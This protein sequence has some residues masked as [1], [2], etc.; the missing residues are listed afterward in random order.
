MDCAEQKALTFSINLHCP[1]RITHNKVLFF[2]ILNNRKQGE[3]LKTLQLSA[4][5]VFLCSNMNQLRF[6][7]YLIIASFLWFSCTD[8][9]TTE[10]F[11]AAK[12]ATLD[13]A[14]LQTYFTARNLKDSV[15]KTS[16]GLYYRITKSNPSEPL[17]T[18]GKRVFVRYE[19]RLLTDTIFDSN[20]NS[21]TAFRFVPGSGAVIKAWEEGILYFRKGEE[22]YLYAPSGLGY[23][24]SPTGRIPANSCLRFFIRVTNVE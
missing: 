2:Y 21:S 15:T 1:D 16:S 24:N 6:N 8:T 23:A 19:G 4:F 5:I 17:I 3:K 12:Q 13:E 18:N 9:S 14:S 11:N 10:V 7:A 22:G 20:L